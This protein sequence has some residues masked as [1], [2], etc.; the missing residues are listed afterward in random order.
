MTHG[1]LPVY[2]SD[3]ESSEHIAPFP[4]FQFFLKKRKEWSLGIKGNPATTKNK[5]YVHGDMNVSTEL[6]LS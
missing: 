5:S 1:W 2:A 6:T 4:K 3:R